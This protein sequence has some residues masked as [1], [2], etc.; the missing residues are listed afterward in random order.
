[1]HVSAC[2]TPRKAGCKVL[3]HCFMTGYLQKYS[4]LV[5]DCY[6]CG[7]AAKCCD[8]FQM[9][10][11]TSSLILS[12]VYVVMVITSLVVYRCAFL[13]ERES[14]CVFSEY[15]WSLIQ[16]V[17]WIITCKMRCCMYISLLNI[18]KT[19]KNS[20]ICIKVG[21][22][23]GCPQLVFGWLFFFFL[24]TSDIFIDFWVHK[25]VLQMEIKC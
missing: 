24:L 10:V 22:V 9:L 13:W 6:E 8:G 7:L 20:P 14:T 1:M 4:S 25:A 18:L 5:W 16:W 15:I 11:G 23:I 2:L 3:F 12:K 21:K 19:N 17:S